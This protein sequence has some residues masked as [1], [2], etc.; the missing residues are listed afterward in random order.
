M[1]PQ[2]LTY[3]AFKLYNK[4]RANSYRALIPSNT[5]NRLYFLQGRAFYRYIR[6]LKSEV[7]D[8]HI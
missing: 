6:R 4:I 1:N 2:D 3:Q 5:W 8:T 7:K